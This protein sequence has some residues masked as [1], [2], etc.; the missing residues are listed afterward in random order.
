MD[1]LGHYEFLIHICFTKFM[2]F[3]WTYLILIS[4]YLL[5]LWIHFTPFITSRASNSLVIC[6]ECFVNASLLILHGP[7]FDYTT[8]IIIR[9]LTLFLMRFLATL[10]SD[11]Y[12]CLWYCCS[13]SAHLSLALTSFQSIYAWLISYDGFIP[14]ISCGLVMSLTLCIYMPIY[15]HQ[16]V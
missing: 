2:G 12:A 4:T 6:Y 15:V 9:E 13:Q 14:H 16:Y 11:R 7:N 5:S 1:F 10:G 8:L 3:L